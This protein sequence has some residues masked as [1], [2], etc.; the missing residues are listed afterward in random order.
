M[1]TSSKKSLNHV[2]N[3]DETKNK[4][5]GGLA[6]FWKAVTKTP[7]P[8]MKVDKQMKTKPFQG[9]APGLPSR[10]PKLLSHHRA[11]GQIRVYHE[12]LVF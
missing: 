11:L 12:L 10:L 9:S 8:K 2:K 7:F 6:M 5:A 3:R 4:E 1:R